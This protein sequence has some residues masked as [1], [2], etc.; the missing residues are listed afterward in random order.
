[1]QR[2][3]VLDARSASVDLDRIHSFVYVC[4][5]SIGLRS[6]NGSINLERLSLTEPSSLMPVEGLSSKNKTLG[7]K[8]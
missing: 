8:Q 4:P 1:M 2:R 5:L 7:S 3:L 6:F